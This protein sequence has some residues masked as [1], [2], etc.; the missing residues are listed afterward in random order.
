MH[1]PD[2]GTRTNIAALVLAVE[3]RPTGDDDGRHITARRPHQQRRGGLVAT[4]QQHNRVHRIAT[5]RLLDIHAGQIACQHGG[6]SQVRFA[7]GEDWE[8]HRETAGL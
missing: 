1:L 6:R 5:N 7:I 2:D 8:L 3:H 4:D